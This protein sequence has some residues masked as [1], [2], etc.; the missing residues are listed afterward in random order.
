MNPS[1]DDS[2]PIGQVGIFESG[3]HLGKYV[4][5]EADKTGTGYHV[6]ILERWPGLLPNN[7]WDAW[8]DDMSGVLEWIIDP[9]AKIRW[10]GR[11]VAK[12]E[13]RR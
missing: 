3:E 5:V 4:L 8:A 9:D 2:I 12:Q 13:K 11:Q 6:W 1:A 10:T 7:G